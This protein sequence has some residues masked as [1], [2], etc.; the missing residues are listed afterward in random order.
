M[1]VAGCSTVDRDAGAAQLVGE[2]V[3]LGQTREVGAQRAHVARPGA[4]ADR[5]DRRR[6]PRVLAPVHQDRRPELGEPDGHLVP[7][8]VGGPGHESGQGLG[9]AHDGGTSWGRRRRTRG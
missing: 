9:G 1:N 7:D 3:D 6:D 8:A 5:R 2:G 4:L